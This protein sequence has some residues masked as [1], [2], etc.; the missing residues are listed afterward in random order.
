MKLYFNKYIAFLGFHYP[1][2]IAGARLLVAQN[3][4]TTN[5]KPLSAIFSQFPVTL[6]DQPPAFDPDVMLELV[7]T[8][9]SFLCLD[10]HVVNP[11]YHRILTTGHVNLSEQ[12]LN[13]PTLT[14]LIKKISA[15]ACREILTERGQVNPVLNNTFGL[16]KLTSSHKVSESI[17]QSFATEIIFPVLLN[18]WLNDNKAQNDLLNLVDRKVFLHKV[19][20][21]IIDETQDMHLADTLVEIWQDDVMIKKIM[22]ASS[23]DL[24]AALQSLENAK[25]EV[26]AAFYSELKMSGLAAFDFMTRHIGKQLVTTIAANINDYVIYG[27][28]WASDFNNKDYLMHISIMDNDL[29]SNLPSNLLKPFAPFKAA[30]IAEMTA[31]FHHEII[32]L[33][34]G[35]P[36][37]EANLN[38]NKFVTKIMLFAYSQLL[39]AE[40][41][42]RTAILSQL[43]YENTA[44]NRQQLI[45]DYL[46]KLLVTI[47][48]RWMQEFQAEFNE[49]NIAH[50]Y[51]DEIVKYI[52]SLLAR[53]LNIEILSRVKGFPTFAKKQSIKNFQLVL[54]DFARDDISLI[55]A[56]AE[57]RAKIDLINE[58]KHHFAV[59]DE[60]HIDGT[61]VLVNILVEV[62]QRNNLFASHFSI[63]GAHEILVQNEKELAELDAG[64]KKLDEQATQLDHQLDELHL[65]HLFES[66]TV[67]QEKVAGYVRAQDLCLQ[68]IASET[69][70]AKVLNARLKQ[71]NENSEMDYLFTFTKNIPGYIHSP[72]GRQIN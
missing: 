1:T 70:K 10:S 15:I 55:H 37:L 58:I 59:F 35:A 30:M 23:S 66:L 41:N 34:M 3:S 67:L 8:L 47:L 64:A 56:V 20:S 46:R 53:G 6:M 72:T 63:D 21:S 14:E 52:E 48:A 61:E 13:Q 57:I 54:S 7:S 42:V 38:I 49:R 43:N 45:T 40:G 33:T 16:D 24:I 36:C 65:S 22:S 11:V 29:T 17:V 44:A 31:Y 69:A 19:F 68:N 50:A 51:L 39:D 9:N 60:E 4:K 2:L 26:T 12:L 5:I 18:A 71:L 27:K 62:Q 28:P 32:M 25:Q